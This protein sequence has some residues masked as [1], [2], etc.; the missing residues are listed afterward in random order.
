MTVNS[1]ECRNA[2]GFIWGVLLTSFIV[3]FC[4]CIYHDRLKKKYNK[5]L[6]EHE[7]LLPEAIMVEELI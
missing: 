3:N 1:L 5:L 2:E 4:Q 6:F 7:S